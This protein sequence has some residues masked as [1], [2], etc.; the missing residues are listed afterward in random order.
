MN[1]ILAPASMVLDRVL[2]FHVLDHDILLVD[3]W[4]SAR[5]PR[6]RTAAGSALVGHL[7]VVCCW[8]EDELGG[9][10]SRLSF[11]S[12]AGELLPSPKVGLE[13]HIPNRR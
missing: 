4:S 3:A 10:L 9:Q 6:G 5:Q 8:R 12:S 13:R 1:M 11:C 2:L 7:A